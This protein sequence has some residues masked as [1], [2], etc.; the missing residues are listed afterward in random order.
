[1]DKT[2]LLRKITSDEE[3][4][5]VL[6]RLLDQWER[7][8]QRNIPASKAFLTPRQQMLARTLLQQSGGS[9]VFAGGYEG[10]ERCMALF[11]PDYLTA[12][13]YA[14]DEEEYPL[15]AVRC[16]YRPEE[17]PTHRDFL[18]SLMGLGIR[19]DTV[20][21]ILVTS[22]SADILVLDTVADFLL[23]SWES[24]GRTR[25]HLQEVERSCIHVP[26]ASTE[27]VRDTVS[28]LRLDAVIAAGLRMSRGKAAEL[29]S[30]GRVQVN[31]ME[32]TKAD[33]PLT[34]G[35]TVSARG[36]G[37]F[38]LAEVGGTTKKGRISVTL[39]RY[40]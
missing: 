39:L 28:S 2:Q 18:G 21:D 10:A 29:V 3:D 30:S 38:R 1:M 40:V 6:A 20:G 14:A 13:W 26:Q 15:C 24:A 35:D 5:L 7:C 16:T 33:K 36:F 37:K 4:R 25:L 17:K 34:E 12:E 23:Q 22:E 19:R 32:C 9:A 8:A 27:E 11:L 31:W